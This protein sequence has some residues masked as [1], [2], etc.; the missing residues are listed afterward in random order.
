MQSLIGMS[1][2]AKKRAARVEARRHG[3]IVATP[4]L[5]RFVLRLW[6][7]ANGATSPKKIGPHTPEPRRCDRSGA[8]G[9]D[10]AAARAALGLA[11]GAVREGA[12]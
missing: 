11:P 7:L 2:S 9:T 10:Y 5:R 8:G 1:R 4:S 12:A 3:E 6:H